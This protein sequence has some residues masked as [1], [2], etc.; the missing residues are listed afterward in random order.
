M[1]WI[2]L[3][4]TDRSHCLRY[5]VLKKLLNK[6]DSD[7]EVK[8]LQILREFDPLVLE[9]LNLQRENGA[10]DSFGMTIV[11]KTENIYITSL[12]L[13]RLGYLG[14]DDKY[15]FIQN[16]AEYLFSKQE[17]DGSWPIPNKNLL[18]DDE[19]GY[20]MMPV[21][22][23]I[24]L[25]GLAMSGYGLDERSEKAYEWLLAQRLDDGA[26]PVGIS[27][28]NYGGIAGYRRLAH[29]R[30]GCRSNTT[31]ALTCLAYHPKRKNSGEAKK[32]LDL[33]LSTDMKLRT[34]MGFNIARLM[35]LEKSI[36]MIT[37]MAKFDI[38]HLLNLCWRIGA[39]VEDSRVKNFIEFV[40]EE[41]TKYGMWT[42]KPQPSASKWLT[43][44]LLLSL[45]QLDEKIEW[46][47]QEPPTPF[48]AYPT[49]L[50]RF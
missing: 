34:S 18:S 15:S 7:P 44:D 16:A 28:G 21:Q 11:G 10:W 32:A 39:S 49:K 42:Y 45:S 40:I 30:W 35:G 9:M 2:P 41:K 37:F 12:V 17:E 33:I 1:T 24:P 19:Q 3:L 29:S 36:G 13:Q 27:A 22:T 4:L 47:S 31:A 26:W 48:K 50:K 14:F 8:E 25:L 38:A 43:Y 20:Q 5:L 6:P 46:M 23:A